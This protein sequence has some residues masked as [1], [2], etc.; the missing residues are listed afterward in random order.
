M[1]KKKLLTKSEENK[2]QD[3]SVK[4]QVELLEKKIREMKAQEQGL[5]LAKE[6]KVKKPRVLSEKQKLYNAYRDEQWKVY[7]SKG[8]T[9]RDMLKDPAYKEGYKNKK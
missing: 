9:F 5:K 7:K 8:V 3:I 4:E 1:G 6:P 2:L